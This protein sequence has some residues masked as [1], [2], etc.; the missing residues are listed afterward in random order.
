VNPPFTLERF[1]GVFVSYNATIRPAQIVAYVLGLFA[2]AALALGLLLTANTKVRI[3]N[4]P[5]AKA[6]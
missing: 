4:E 1:L 6:L 3:E 5:A 2:V